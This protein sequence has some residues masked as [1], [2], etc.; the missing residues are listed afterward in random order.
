M[1]GYTGIV[2]AFK[3]AARVA[4][5]TG[6]IGVGAI[7]AEARTE[8]IERLLCVDPANEQQQCG[9]QQA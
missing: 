4:T 1:T 3:Y 7:E 5:L 2:G 8:M 6:N 9:Y